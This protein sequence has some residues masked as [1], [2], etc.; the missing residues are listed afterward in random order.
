M[1]SHFNFKSLAFY[2]GA[3]AFVLILFNVVSTYGIANL[4]APPNIN[5][6]YQISAQNLPGCLKSETLVLSIQ[7]SGIYL[8]G[9]L[10]P[11]NSDK[12][13][14]SVSA[15]PSLAGKFEHQQVSLVGK[16]PQLANCDR[17]VKIE[18]KFEGKTLTGQISLAAI[19]GA[20]EFTAQQEAPIQQPK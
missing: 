17:P 13:A 8:G 2:G 10:L 1:K 19:P 14:T 3:I 20:V 12:E 7:Q 9:S 18:G 15:R 4:K 6:R 16:A 5:G 11:G